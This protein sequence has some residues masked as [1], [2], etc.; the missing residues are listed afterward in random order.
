MRNGIEKKYR[1]IS[2]KT[3]IRNMSNK[4]VGLGYGR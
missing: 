3:F 4:K 2:V 1:N